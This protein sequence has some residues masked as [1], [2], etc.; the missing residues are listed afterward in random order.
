MLPYI[1]Y[2]DPMGYDLTHWIFDWTRSTLEF[3][4]R[5]MIKFTPNTEE[6]IDP[7]QSDGINQQFTTESS[8]LVGGWHTHMRT[9][10]LVY[11]PT[12]LADFGQGK[13]LVCIFQHHGSSGI[14]TPLKND[15]LSLSVEM[16]MTFPTERFQSFKIPWFQMVP[17]GSS[18]HQ[19]VI[20]NH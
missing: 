19:A 5:S 2:M 14:P 4:K 6:F 13:M 12:K 16:M 8:C 3:W 7:I 18:H 17:D 9:M 10:V 15:G 20:I 1:A 11:L